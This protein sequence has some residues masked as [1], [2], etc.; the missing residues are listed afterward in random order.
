MAKIFS[1]CN[2]LQARYYKNGN[3]AREG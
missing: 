2:R 1:V 3:G